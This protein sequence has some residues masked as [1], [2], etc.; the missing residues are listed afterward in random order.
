MGRRRRSVLYPSL[1]EYGCLRKLQFVASGCITSRTSAFP[2]RRTSSLSS[3]DCQ[4]QENPRWGSTSCLR[5][6]SAS[7]W[8]RSEWWSSGSPSH[9][10]TRS[11]AFH[12]PSAWTSTSPTTARAP[13]LAPSPTYI[14]TCVYCLPGLDIGP[15]RLAERTFRPCPT[16]PGRDGQASPPPTRTYPLPRRPSHALI[17]APR[18]RRSTWRTS[19]LINP[20]VPALRVPG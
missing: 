15:A 6:G 16:P 3:P 7:I 13:P 11:P 1:L 4:V 17:A 2:S 10:S 8:S 19:P 18:F 20:R 9:P 14:P 12:R 5:K